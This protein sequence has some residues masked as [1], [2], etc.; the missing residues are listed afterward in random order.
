MQPT[1]VSPPNSNRW[2][3]CIATVPNARL[4]LFCFP[5]AGGNA[6]AFRKWA[7]AGLEGVD[8]YAI[9]LPGRGTRLAEPAFDRMEPLVRELETALLPSF[10]QPF[11]FFGH[12]MGAAIAYELLQT[13]RSR[14]L[15]PSLLLVSGRRAPHIA[16]PDPPI[17]GLPEADFLHALRRYNGTPEEVL[18]STELMALFLPTIRADFTLLETHA[19]QP[20]PPLDCPIVAF[21]GLEDWKA[22]TGDLEAWRAHTRANFSHQMFPGDH[23]FIDSARSSLLQ[24]I[25]TALENFLPSAST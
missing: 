12:S 15:P 5:Y 13:L 14:D 18:Q 2:L 20:R 16:D 21:G 6:F 7:D 10:I 24:A 17:H 25:D 11:A 22:S 19:Y 3:K 23:F 4:R 9:E 8:L 1:I